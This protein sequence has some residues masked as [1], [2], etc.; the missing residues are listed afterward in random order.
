MEKWKEVFT[1]EIPS[2]NYETKLSNGEE[3]GEYVALA[4]HQNVDFPW[5]EMEPNYWVM[6]YLN[7]SLEQL[8]YVEDKIEDNNT[9]DICKDISR[10]LRKAI[11]NKKSVL[12]RRN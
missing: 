8:K 4:Y 1:D 11:N 5:E 12:I 9:R 10:I 7:E 2:G 3:D 6:D